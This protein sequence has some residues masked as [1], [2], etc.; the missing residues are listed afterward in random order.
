MIFARVKISAS[1]LATLLIWQVSAFGQATTGSISGRVVDPTGA[2]VGGATVVISNVDNG[3]K[4]T[5]T[6]NDD[7]AFNETALPPNNYQI[8][9]DKEGFSSATLETFK[10]DIDQKARFNVELKVGSTATD[11]LVTGSAP[12]LQVQGAETGQVIGAREI[13]DLPILG[14]DFSGLMLLVP[15]VVSGG[16][17]NNLNL[18]VNGQR[19]FSNSV[20]INGVEVTGNRN[21]DTNVRPSP[22]AI[23]AF[24]VVTSSYAP[25]FG[26]A[27]GGSVI[28]QTKAGTNNLHGSAFYFYRPTAT[29]ANQPFAPAGSTPLLQQHNY[30]ATIGG[31][32]KKDKA[33]FFLAYEGIRNR[34]ESAYAGETPPTNQVSFL[35]NGDADL[36]KL[37]DPLSGTQI[38]IFDPFFFQTNFYAQQ[39]PGNIIPASEISPAGKRILQQLFP[40]PQNNSFFTNFNVVQKTTLDSNVANLRLDYTFSQNNRVYLTYDAEQGDTTAADPYAGK[41]PIPGAGSGDSG[42]L[43]GYENHVIG[44]SFDHVFSPTLL[45]ESRIN[46]FLSTVTQHS[47]LD[48]TDLATQ[49]GIQNA[50]IPGF[51]DT[52]SF[53]QIQF[54]SGPTAGGS[55]YKPLTFRDQNTG[56][57][58]ALSWTRGRHNAKFGYEFRHLHSHPDFSLFPV[59]YEYFGGPDG[60][61]T[62][63]QTYANYDAS[64]YYFNGGSEIAD[65]L[66]G[67]PY[68]VDQGLALTKPDTSANEHSFYLQDY[69]QVTN[70]LNL[71]YGVRYEYQQPYVDANNGEANFD[72]ATLRM[73]LAGRGSN[74]RSLVN[75]NTR[76]FMPRVGLAYQVMPDTVVRAGYG[77]FY[78]PENDAREDILTKNYPFFTQQQFVNTPYGLVYQ[79]DAGVARPTSIPVPS[80]VS[81]IDVTS[82]PD[83]NV[84]TVFSEPKHFPTAYSQNYNL[85]VEH[86]LNGATSFEVGYVGAKT[87]HLSYEVG[88]YNVANHISASIGKVQTLLP[89]GLSNYNSLQA[90]LNRN[91]K[92]GYSILASYTWAHAF[93]NGPAPFDLGKGTNLPQNPFNISS[94][95]SNSDGDVRHNFVM[96]QIIELPFGRGKR[97]LTGSSGVGQTL[98]GG[99]QLNSITTIHTGIP[100][101]IVSNDANQNYP[102]LRPDLVGDPNVSHRT[103]SAW[104]NTSAF[105]VPAMQPTNLIPGD[106]PR[107]FLY[108][109]GNTNEDVSLFK[110]LSL[111]REMKFQ[112]RIEAFNVLN[113]P[114]YGNPINDKASGKF[115]E[116]TTG[117]G[118]RVMQFAGRLVF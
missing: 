96:S 41:I 34:D 62:S 108:G 93:D 82:I 35:P 47:P 45:S 52:F 115:G 9:V 113:T 10:L 16:G 37:T 81:S 42:D 117:G 114:H 14:R 74:S 17:G 12:I 105:V 73:D 31:T 38:P 102:G 77:I 67:L 1:L 32:I 65:L 33:F 98:L 54:E 25:E 40:V 6:T 49:F 22:D 87:I 99:W 18:S 64:R 3:I 15:G 91:F 55:T 46:Y 83:F 20:Q 2:N 112:I 106:T 97:F 110:V 101:N 71:T 100:F 61:L 68:V 57:V 72:I 84:Q 39:Y 27:S 76:D 92:H 24:K 85:T 19:E 89:V 4:T 53:P 66:L 79:L 75:S 69:W 90:K 29:A 116:I 26:R 44:L 43:T 118:S 13:E 21:N 56:F 70:R 86:Q 60:S 107:N 48:G 63:D 51:P 80:G 28:I 58:E 59:P 50:N 94:E 5:A 109:P 36:S 8:T 11:I 104:F 7:G 23:E 111:P 103:K 88:D 95:Y 30:G 78:S